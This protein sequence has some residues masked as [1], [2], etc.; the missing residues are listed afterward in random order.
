MMMTK[1][2]SFLAHFNALVSFVKY[3]V[4]SKTSILTT[5]LQ[6]MQQVYYLF[7]LM[8][9]IFKEFQKNI[10]IAIRLYYLGSI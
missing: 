7:F 2:F 6:I 3:Y 5:T 1:L 8:Q 4:F 9:N 10:Q